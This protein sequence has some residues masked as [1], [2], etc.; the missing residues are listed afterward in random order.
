[1]PQ[2]SKRPARDL[3]EATDEQEDSP[4]TQSGSGKEYGD[5][6]CG[7]FEWPARGRRCNGRVGASGAGGALQ[8]ELL[9]DLLQRGHD[10]GHHCA[11]HLF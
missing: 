11:M 3:E 1:M 4:V 5:D 8:H 2:G 6:G 10:E 9:D 7:E